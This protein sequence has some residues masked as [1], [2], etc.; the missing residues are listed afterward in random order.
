M[1]S[2]L[3]RLITVLAALCLLVAC[4]GQEDASGDA[5]PDHGISGTPVITGDPAD[6]NFSDITFATT[7][8]RQH[9]QAIEL[10]QMV[11]QRS[12]NPELVTLAGQIVA[13]QQ[14]EINILNVFLVQWN[15]NPE[16]RSD[17]EA[18]EDALEP[19]IQGMVDDATVAVSYTHLTLPTNREV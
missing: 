9:Q 12:A 19:S 2:I 13:T 14:P 1:T 11:A 5:E 10:S 6:Y 7:T 4:G 18:G 3:A 15:E 17:P 8:V 16:N